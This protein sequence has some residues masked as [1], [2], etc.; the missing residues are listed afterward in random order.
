MAQ[1]PS[2]NINLATQV[3]DVL[4]SKGGSVNNNLLS[5]FTSSAKINP[6]S[7]YKPIHTGYVNDDFLDVNSSHFADANYGL[8]APTT[9]D[10]LTAWN[11]YK[12]AIT[13][14]DFSGLQWSYELPKGGS[15]SP[16]RLGDFRLY[17]PDARSPFHEVS[18]ESSLWTPNQQYTVEVYNRYG[19]L[20]DGQI[21]LGEMTDYHNLYL[22]VMIGKA[23]TEGKA[24]YLFTGGTVK[25]HYG[26]QNI[27]CRISKEGTY[28]LAPVL[29]Q[30]PENTSVEGIQSN[31]YTLLPVKPL[32]VVVE[33]AITA[34]TLYGDASIASNGDL[35]VNIS[36]TNATTSNLSFNNVTIQVGY[37]DSVGTGTL[38][39]GV[40]GSYTVG[41]YKKVTA[42][43][44]FL[45]SGLVSE[46]QQ[47]KLYYRII[48]NGG[49]YTSGEKQLTIAL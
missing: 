42:N 5:F 8:T 44:M 4:N 33:A 35:Y 2:N 22:G 49:S 40:I 9:N 23:G 37:Q 21:A 43:K 17:N 15:S 47:G 45:A 18:C 25:Q 11:A 16:Y 19:Y 12:K 29:C 34:T 6:W 14:N 32:K 24:E 36:M 13:N 3:R 20:N 41:S 10:E 30:N 38:F 39:T 46:A 1:I 7:K 27:V 26:V 31:N 28:Y 48:A